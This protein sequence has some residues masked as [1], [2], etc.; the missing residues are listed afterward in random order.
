MPFYCE[1]GI[2][3]KVV[4]TTKYPI[5]YLR[6]DK[7]NTKIETGNY[8]GCSKSNYVEI[9]TWH[10]DWGND[11]IDSH[12]YQRVCKKCAKE[13]I[14]EYIDEM[15]GSEELEFSNEYLTDYDFTS[16]LD[17]DYRLAEKDVTNDSI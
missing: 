12:E 7:C 9:H 2:E 15:D 10:S 3:Q 17:N 6:C 1:E 8:G 14:C 11:S 4:T 13:F 16:S 5:K